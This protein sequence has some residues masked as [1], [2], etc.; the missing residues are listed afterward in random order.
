MIEIGHENRS[1]CIVCDLYQCD[2]CKGAFT[3]IL[4]STR[5]MTVTGKL[6]RLFGARL[7]TVTGKFR[8]PIAVDCLSQFTNRQSEFSSHSHES[9]AEKSQ[10]KQTFRMV[11]NLWSE[12]RDGKIYL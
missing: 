4:F 10:C 3:R 1:P 11:A 6:L 8:L 2:T 9:S 12:Y 7:V 5:L